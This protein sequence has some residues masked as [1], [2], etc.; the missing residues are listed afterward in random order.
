MSK[1][2]EQTDEADSKTTESSQNEAEQHSNSDHS[3]LDTS[4][5]TS[6]PEV[7]STASNEEQNTKPGSDPD[8]C[9]T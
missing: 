9:E 7:S 2:K 3:S 1:L 6:Q 4:Q 8:S 5:T